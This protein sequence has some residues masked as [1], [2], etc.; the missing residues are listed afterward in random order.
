MSV[1]TKGKTQKK[2]RKKKSKKNRREVVWIPIYDE[3]GS[4]TGY[5][6]KFI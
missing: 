2:K 4:L 6:P 5:Q 1:K 3:S